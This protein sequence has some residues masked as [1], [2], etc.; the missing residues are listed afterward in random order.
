MAWTM[1]SSLR[2]DAGHGSGALTDRYI[3]VELQ[4]RAKSARKKIIDQ[5]EN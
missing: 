5:E 2:D 1:G 4:A 3:V